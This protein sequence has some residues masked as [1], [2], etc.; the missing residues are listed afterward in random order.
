LGAGTLASVGALAGT[1]T[2]GGGNSFG[3]LNV[4]KALRVMLSVTSVMYLL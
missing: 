3:E 4:S 2:V 1:G